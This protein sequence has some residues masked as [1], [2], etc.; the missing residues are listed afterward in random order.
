MCLNPPETTP[1]PPP[2]SVKKL[3]YMKLVP[4]AKKFGDPCPIAL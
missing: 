4:G 1:H 3:S 2:Q